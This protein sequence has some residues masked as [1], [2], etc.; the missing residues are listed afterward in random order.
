VQDDKAVFLVKL[1][2]GFGIAKIITPLQLFLVLLMA[3]SIS[4]KSTLLTISKEGMTVPF[5]ILFQRV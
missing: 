4:C 5:R 1:E 3:L 2:G